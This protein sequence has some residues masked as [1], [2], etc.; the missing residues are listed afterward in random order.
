M[1]IICYTVNNLL[2]FPMYLVVG[3]IKNLFWLLVG[4]T[5]R[6]STSVAGF[7]TILN[8]SEVIINCVVLR[9]SA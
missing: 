6:A 4:A 2:P 8:T 7:I 1:Y 9:Q 5:A 3:G